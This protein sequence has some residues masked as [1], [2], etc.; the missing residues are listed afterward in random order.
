[1]CRLTDTTGHVHTARMWCR[2]GM[3]TLRTTAS[4]WEQSRCRFSGRELRCNRISIKI[5][6]SKF[7]QDMEPIAVPEKVATG[8]LQSRSATPNGHDLLSL[9]K[10]MREAKPMPDLG[11]G[12]CPCHHHLSGSRSRTLLGRTALMDHPRV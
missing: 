10:L 6:M 4:T 9:N 11:G 7:V 12:L 2:C 5:C 3:D 8:I 1:M